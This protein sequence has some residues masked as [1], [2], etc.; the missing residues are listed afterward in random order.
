MEFYK[1]E[2][3]LINAAYAVLSDATKRM[4]YDFNLENEEFLN[5]AQQGQ[6]YVC[7]CQFGQ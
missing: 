4:R 7:I 2:T 1:Q 3:Q 6:A 5:Q